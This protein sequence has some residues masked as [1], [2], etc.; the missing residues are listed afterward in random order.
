MVMERDVLGSFVFYD[1]VDDKT[2]R[3]QLDGLGGTYETRAD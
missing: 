1:T 3:K 2:R